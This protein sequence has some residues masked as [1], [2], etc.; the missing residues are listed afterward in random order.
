MLSTPRAAIVIALIFTLGLSGCA[1]QRGHA[2]DRH[3][4]RGYDSG[5]AEARYGRV[6]SIEPMQAR[7]EGSGAGAL[8]GGLIGGLIGNQMGKG[9]GRAAATA[10]GAVGGAMLGHEI[11]RQNQGERRIHRVTVRLERRGEQQ[12]DLERL[13]GLRV[14]DRVRI[15][16]GRLQRL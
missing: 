5:F 16:N 7:G 12:F 10:I 15:D 8:A 14:G 2:R 9:N 3:E 13:D 4:D 11:E 6:Q 1:H